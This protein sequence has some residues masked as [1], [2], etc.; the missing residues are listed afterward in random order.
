MDEEQPTIGALVA[1]LCARLG[2]GDGPLVDDED[3][4]S[5]A[6]A[7]VAAVRDGTAEPALRALFEQL[8]AAMRR[9][10]LAHGLGASG[11][12][13]DPPVRYQGLPGLQLSLIHI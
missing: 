11:H 13:A 12:R 10:G 2:E 7:A 5:L 4:R 8:E 3:I 1:A 6:A 9:A